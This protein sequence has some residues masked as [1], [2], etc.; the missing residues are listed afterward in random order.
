[1]MEIANFRQVSRNLVWQCAKLYCEIWKEPPWNEDFWQPA[2][3]MRDITQQ[4]KKTKAVGFLGIQNGE[5]VGF[6]WAYA[7]TSTDMNNISGGRNLDYLFQTGNQVF[8]IDELAVS[9]RFRNQ[10]KGESLSRA[11]LFEIKK[12][13]CNLITLRTDKK[14]KA[15]RLLYQ[16]LGFKDQMIEDKKY[17]DRTYWVLSL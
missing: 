1:M 3:V 7:V 17:P 10:G 12:S 8:Y 9:P 5:V 16:K 13:G 2:E 15:A 11:L 4:L 14:A 6:T